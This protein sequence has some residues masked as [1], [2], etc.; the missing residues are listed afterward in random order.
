MSANNVMMIQGL[1]GKLDHAPGSLRHADTRRI[2]DTRLAEF[3]HGAESAEALVLGEVFLEA[4][5][6]FSAVVSG[7]KAALLG[8][9]LCWEPDD[10]EFALWIAGNYGLLSRAGTRI[11]ERAAARVA[12]DDVANETLLQDIVTSALVSRGHALKWQAISGAQ[13]ASAIGRAHSLYRLAERRGFAHARA[14][15]LHEEMP[16]GMTIEGLYLR[17][18]LLD[19]LFAGNLTRQ[20][21]E[22]LDTLLWHWVSDYRLTSA[23]EP[24]D[25]GLWVDVQSDAGVRNSFMPPSGLDV[26]FLVVARLEEQLDQVIAGFHAGEVYPGVGVSCGFRIE[27]HVAVLGLLKALVTRLRRSGGAPRIAKRSATMARVEGYVGLGEI[28]QRGMRRDLDSGKERD[29]RWFRIRDSSEGGVR[30]VTEDRDW[31]PIEVGD[32]VGFR[33]RDSVVIG[34]VV[35]KLP[36]AEP[37]CSQLGVS[38]LTRE[39]QMLELPAAGDA[40]TGSLD[41][42]YV[43]GEDASGRWDAMLLSDTSLARFGERDCTLDDRTYR[44]AINR[45]RRQGRGWVLAG[46]EVAGAKQAEPGVAG[47]KPASVAIA[48]VRQSAAA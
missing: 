22:V 2:W 30:L 27:E 12:V 26:R 33:D 19:F 23:P 14:H 5:R 32:L 31:Q 37:G 21:V 4:R 13:A 36:D 42:I 44:I 40:R 45:V 17:V 10:R 29:R 24:G 16:R 11:A 46:F 25:L 38:L 15:V 34:E 47:V 6:D 1:E 48:A 3:T 28:S 20:Q 41:A 7:A 39:P 9:Q 35:R 8:N 43:P 18:L